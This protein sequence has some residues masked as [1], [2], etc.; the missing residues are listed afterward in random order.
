[1]AKYGID[2]IVLSDGVRA[3]VLVASLAEGVGL[4]AGEA[5]QGKASRGESKQVG[6]VGISL[7]LHGIPHGVLWLPGDGSQK[8]VSGAM[9]E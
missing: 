9:R 7:V 1:L 8:S 6:R 2:R 4:G 5:R 3:S